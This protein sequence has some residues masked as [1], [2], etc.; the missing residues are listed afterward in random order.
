MPSSVLKTEIH[1]QNKKQGKVGAPGHLATIRKL[2][3]RG[4]QLNEQALY[5]I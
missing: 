3:N 4:E 2:K 5:G 1:T